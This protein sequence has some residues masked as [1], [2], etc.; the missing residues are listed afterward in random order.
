MDSERSDCCTVTPSNAFVRLGSL[1]GTLNRPNPTR[2][3]TVSPM[4]FASAA[5]AARADALA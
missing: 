1:R 2:P 3:R 5:L 4:N